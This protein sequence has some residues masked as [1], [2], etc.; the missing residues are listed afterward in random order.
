M[1]Q[2]NERYMNIPISQLTGIFE[3]Q[4]HTFQK[5]VKLCIYQHAIE[6]LFLRTQV[7]R[8]IKSGEFYH[9]S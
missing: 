5:I 7:E 1:K 8:I 6:R 3:N 9:L 2:P 4:H